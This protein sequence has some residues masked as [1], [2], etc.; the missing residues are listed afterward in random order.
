MLEKI[1]N[2]FGYYKIPRYWVFK[3]R[4]DGT[5]SRFANNGF[6]SVFNHYEMLSYTSKLNHMKIKYRIEKIGIHFD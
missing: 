4:D 6:P 5:E 1:M 2:Y 3:I